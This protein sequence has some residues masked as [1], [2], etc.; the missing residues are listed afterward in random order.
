MW[1]K[2]VLRVLQISLE[3]KASTP[4]HSPRPNIAFLIIDRSILYRRYKIMRLYSTIG[5]YSF[6][7]AAEK[8]KGPERTRARRNEVDVTQ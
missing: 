7:I 8:L 6:F 3:I 5:Q 1:E 4:N 2:C